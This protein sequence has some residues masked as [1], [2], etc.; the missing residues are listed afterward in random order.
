MSIPTR[1]LS[2]LLHSL[3]ALFMVACSLSLFAQG[4]A[5]VTVDRNPVVAGTP[6]RITFQFKDARVDFSSPPSIE[7]LRF[8]SGP[9]TSNSTQIING[10]M[11]SSR[12]YTYSAVVAKEGVLRIPALRFPSGREMLTTSPISLRVLKAA[13][14]TP[15][16]LPNSRR[17]LKPTS[18]PSSSVN[19]SASSTASTTDSTVWTSGI[20]PSPTSRRLAGNRGRRRP[21]VGKHRHQWPAVPS[22]HHPHRPALPHA[23]RHPRARGVRRGGPG[24]D[25]LLQHASSGVVCAVNKH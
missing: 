21:T 13:S 18:A 15:P 1:P 2:G 12:S 11:S 20:T 19:R 24:E 8:L 25:L 5:S 23:D 4:S 14:A 6:F 9:S 22:G 17:S 3:I 7:G 16:A 10:A